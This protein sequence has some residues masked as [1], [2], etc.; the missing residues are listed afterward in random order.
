LESS[1]AAEHA[2]LNTIG[3][4]KKRPKV[5]ESWNLPRGTRLPIGNWR[6][7]EWRTHMSDPRYTDPLDPRRPGERDPADPA[8]QRRLE[9]EDDSGRGTM[10]AWIVGIIAIIVVAMLVYD[11]NK[12][13]SSTASNPPA[14]SSPSTTGAAPP[15]PPR[16]NPPEAV[17][18][19]APATPAPGTPAPATP[20]PPT[21]S[22]G[23]SP[24]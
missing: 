6:N 15:A 19:P 4:A 7:A 21:P 12:P 22:P 13:I 24:R 8:M 3:N 20:A 2:R 18:T 17:P 1:T 11:Y 23:D 9:L 10:W 5:P 14:A 16:L